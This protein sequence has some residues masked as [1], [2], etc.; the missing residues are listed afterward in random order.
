MI[1]QMIT[2]VAEE[3]FSPKCSKQLHE[4]KAMPPPPPKTNDTNSVMRWNSI[5]SH[6]TIETDHIICQSVRSDSGSTDCV[7]QK[8][9]TTADH[10][11]AVEKHGAQQKCQVI[12]LEKSTDETE[13]KKLFLQ[14]QLDDVIV[15]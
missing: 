4:K 11:A 5:D 7:Q 9:G 13:V 1:T 2:K 12:Q 8:I 14:K 10:W 15:E 6:Q 3:L